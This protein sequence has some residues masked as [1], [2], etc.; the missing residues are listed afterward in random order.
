MAKK[1]KYKK[2]VTLTEIMMVVLISSVI[3]GIVMSMMR[4]NNIQ[5]KKSND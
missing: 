2:A 5:F 3:M 4:R 1:A